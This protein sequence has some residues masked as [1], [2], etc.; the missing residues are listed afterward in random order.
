MFFQ[1]VVLMSS[2][3]AQVEKSVHRN[4]RMLPDELVE[5]SGLLDIIFG[6]AYDPPHPGEVAIQAPLLLCWKG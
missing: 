4:L 1:G 3:A 5:L 6:R 2:A